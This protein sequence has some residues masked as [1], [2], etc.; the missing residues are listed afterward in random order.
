MTVEIGPDGGICIE[1]FPAFHI[2]QHRPSAAGN[3]DGFAAQPVAHLR[4]GMPDKFMIQ[5]D[6]PVLLGIFGAQ[7]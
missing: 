7:F 4:K 5:L 2:A 6:E 1:K 3:D